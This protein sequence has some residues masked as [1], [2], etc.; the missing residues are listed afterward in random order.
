[1][2]LQPTN[3]SQ[4]TQ[5]ASLPLPASSNYMETQRNSL[6][7]RAI[8]QQPSMIETD[9]NGIATIATV[10]MTD[11]VGSATA[12]ACNYKN[13]TISGSLNCNRSVRRSDIVFQTPQHTRIKRE[14]DLLGVVSGHGLGQMVAR[15][16]HFGIAQAKLSPAHD[17]LARDD[18]INDPHKMNRTEISVCRSSGD[19]TEKEKT[20]AI[21]PPPLFDETMI[22]S[23]TLPLL[24]N[25]SIRQ[26]KSRRH[27]RTI[28]RH[29]TVSTSPNVSAYPP[30]ANNGASIKATKL[31]D[32]H[33]KISP[34]VC[35]S[36]STPPSSSSSSTAASNKKLI[37]QC[38]V[39]HVPMTYMGSNHLNLTRNHSNDMLLTTLAKNVAKSASFTSSPS[40]QC[41]QRNSASGL[42]SAAPSSSRSSQSVSS[43]H[44]GSLHLP[45]TPV[46]ISTIS[47][48]IGNN[49]FD[50]IMPAMSAQIV[51]D[52]KDTPSSSNGGTLT[53]IELM[54][55]ETKPTPIIANS[56]MFASSPFPIQL[57]ESMGKT[58][59]NAHT[60]RNP[61]LPPKM[62][63]MN[64]S[65]Q[66]QPSSRIH[67]ISKP[68]GGSS[69]APS[70]QITLDQ[71]VKRKEHRE[72]S[73]SPSR[74]KSLSL[75]SAPSSDSRSHSSQNSKTTNYPTTNFA[76][77][78]NANHYTLPKPTT[79]KMSLNSTINDVVNKVPSIVNI[80]TSYQRTGKSGKGH[81]SNES[82][83]SSS[84][85]AN[86][87]YHA[88]T[89][90]TK[91]NGSSIATNQSK[92]EDK[93]LPVCTTYTNC[94]NP[95]EHFLPNDTSLDDDY[96]S[97]CEN[98][99]SA[100]G[101]RYYLDEENDEQPQETMTLQRKMDEKEEE[102]TYYRTSST[103]PTNTKQ[104]TT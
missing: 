94:S 65:S 49:E 70:P 4:Q 31:N 74:D 41:Y 60:E 27:H 56:D 50:T 17:H 95:K 54:P 69:F 81:T 22:S 33:N 71:P 37:C 16:R 99:K 9:M 25:D 62:Y 7:D 102:Q 14:P 28:P 36:T 67:T 104:K 64:G 3:Q 88:L 34:A 100:H 40:T 93:P 18:D 39:Q 35:A 98:C 51:A 75:S 30:P 91:S 11:S 89:S 47:K 21:L 44:S 58:K 13:C 97:E 19:V 57:I 63:K 78:P 90:H 73:K 92:A 26:I 32:D 68:I 38:P 61:V 43:G 42:L 87:D 45:K 29:F 24:P 2:R 86:M 66:Q 72:H 10:N 76:M 85:F 80:P 46:K 20:N 77:L 103:L 84:T 15:P 52:G 23:N 83:S 12:M 1:M 101:S 79:A 96:L 53:K 48:H 55:E 59:E 6:N 8:E 5:Y 82:K